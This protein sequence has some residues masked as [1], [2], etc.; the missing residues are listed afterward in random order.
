[1]VSR[2]RITEVIENNVNPILAEHFGGAELSEFEDGIVWVR[3]T[4]ECASCPSAID[5]VESVVKSIILDTCEG[6]TDVRL[7]LSLSDEL[8]DIA[9]KLLHKDVK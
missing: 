7:D 2:D 8:M 1:M 9:K 6:V 3:L 4:G 5:T